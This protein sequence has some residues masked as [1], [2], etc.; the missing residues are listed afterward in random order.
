[1]RTKVKSI[2]IVIK[3][4]KKYNVSKELIKYLL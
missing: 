1:M 4:M 3:L 2:F